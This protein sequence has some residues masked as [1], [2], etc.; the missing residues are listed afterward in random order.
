M[1]VLSE[2]LRRALA[3]HPAPGLRASATI[4]AVALA[5]VLVAWPLV[6]L[7]VTVCHEA[8]HAVVAVLAGRRLSG[9][10]VHSDTSG[11]TVSRGRPR[12]PG[13]VATLLAGYPAAAVLGLGAAWLAGAGH[14]VGVLWLIVLLL[15]VMLLQLRNLYGAAVVL[16]TGVLVGVVS[17]YASPAVA[18]WLANGIAWMLLLAAPRPVVELLLRHS[19][20]SDAAQLAALTRVPR[21]VWALLWLALTLGALGLGAT[22]LLPGAWP[23]PS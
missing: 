17:W 9:I 11:L 15:A 19:P 10:R 13:M 18:G 20:G 8:G 16:A 4:G 2:L 23:G 1:E 21:A 5:A 6:R 12:G 3:A 14:A 7:L 22:W